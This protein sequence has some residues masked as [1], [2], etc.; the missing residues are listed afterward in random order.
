MRRSI[1]LLVASLLSA[2]W[3]SCVV[4]TASSASSG[5]M[6]PAS[7]LIEAKGAAAFVHS[8]L[9]DAPVP[10]GAAKLA[11]S[12]GLVDGAG[13]A[14]ITDLLDV[15][16]VFS[17]SRPI[18]L[19]DFLKSHRPADAT[20][21]PQATES[22]TNM[23]YE[24]SFAY[25]FVFA[26]RHVSYERLDYSLA[27]TASGMEL[28]RIDAQSVWLPVVTASMPTTSRVVLSGYDHL[29]LA[30]GPS[31]KVSITLTSNQATKLA[32][33]ISLLSNSAGGLCAEGSPLFVVS[34][35][36]SSSS[37]PNSWTATAEECPAVL[38]VVTGTHRVLLDDTSCTLRNLVLSDFPRGKATATRTA[39]RDSCPR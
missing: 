32:R 37:S 23:P 18:H 5:P 25:S 35:S 9:R 31:G 27:S 7:N 16:E 19:G 26:N 3:L 29:S 39:L 13:R 24:I 17:I 33:V 38:D 6:K 22:G 8:L 10:A 11:D 28:L 14:D 4:V 20:L 12:D 2:T 21:G 1:S 36:T 30:T 34:T 15:H